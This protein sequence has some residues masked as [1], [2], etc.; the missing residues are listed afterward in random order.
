MRFKFCPSH[1]THPSSDTTHQNPVLLS[2][3]MTQSS[4][5]YL[6]GIKLGKNV[7][8]TK[9]NLSITRQKILSVLI[10]PIVRINYFTFKLQFKA[11]AAFACKPYPEVA[12]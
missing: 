7:S 5:L 8:F 11:S 9:S 2:P 3:R 4:T 1:P 12:S 10:P 6:H